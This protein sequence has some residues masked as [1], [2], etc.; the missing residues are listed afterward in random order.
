MF[1]SKV[2]RRADMLDIAQSAGAD[3]RPLYYILSAGRTGTVFLEKLIKT[4][5]SDV[6]AEHEPSPSRYLMMLGNLRNDTG[7]LTRTTRRFAQKHRDTLHCAPQ[8]YIEIN[9]F[10]CPVTD[11]L[12]DTNRPLRIVHMLREPGAWAH[13]MTTFKASTKYRH[14]IDFVP[15][16]KPFPAPRPDNWSRLSPFEK[17]LHRWNWCNER[18]AALAPLA[19]SYVQIRSEDMF[20]KDADIQRSTLQS[21]SDTLDLG[22]PSDISQDELNT[23]VNPAPNGIDLRDAKAEKAICGAVASKF[24][25]DV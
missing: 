21:I 16:A 14:I 6:I 5:C 10:L 23:K 2:T 3:A 22:L 18:I 1:K 25:Y 15:W 19:D 4:H 20:S 8:Q 13:S 7:W 11:L 17:S 12:A 24:G 9:P